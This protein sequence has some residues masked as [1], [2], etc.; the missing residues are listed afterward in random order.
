MEQLREEELR[1]EE[2]REEQQ[3]EEQ[4]REEQQREEELGEE[5]LREELRREEQERREVLGGV[6]DSSM[7]I[8][9]IFGDFGQHARSLNFN[10][11]SWEAVH[12]L[13]G[14]P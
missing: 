12:M 4:Q 9:R 8:R 10:F 14:L 7:E 11:S 2:L 5:E 3:R 6:E 13:Y 1:V